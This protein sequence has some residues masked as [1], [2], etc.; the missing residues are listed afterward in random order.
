[1]E[2][3]KF[4]HQYTFWATY[5]N[6]L[7]VKILWAHSWTLLDLFGKGWKY[8]TLFIKCYHK[9]GFARFWNL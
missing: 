8:T 5:L 3:N 9:A 4:K 6:P 1:M 2:R 7:S